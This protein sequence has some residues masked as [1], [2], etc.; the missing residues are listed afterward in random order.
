MNKLITVTTRES[1]A[2]MYRYTGTS[3]SYFQKKTLRIDEKNLRS[4]FQLPDYHFEIHRNQNLIFL[5]HPIAVDAISRGV[6]RPWQTREWERYLTTYD[7][8]RRAA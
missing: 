2:S 1:H 6:Q 7:E 3:F 8:E 5:A 4:K